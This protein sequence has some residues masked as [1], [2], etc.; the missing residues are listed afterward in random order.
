MKLL[1]ATNLKEHALS[2]SLIET[3]LVLCRVGLDDMVFLQTIPYKGW[4]GDLGSKG[5]SS[6]F[7][8]ETK[9]SLPWVLSVAKRENVSLIA[10]NLDRKARNPSRSSFIKGIT[11]RS[12]VPILITNGD[13]T[14]GKGLFEHVVFA[15]DWSPASEKALTFLLGF[16]KIIGE[17]DI[18]NVIKGKLTLKNMRELKE[19]LAHIRKRCL[20][21]KIDAETHIYAG[22]T[23]EEIITASRDYKATLIVMGTLSKKPGYK[24][25]LGGSLSYGIAGKAAVPVLIV[26]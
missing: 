8:V 12:P 19:R 1:Y 13:A 18:V 23:S 20:D 4:L 5:I 6:R 7:L 24:E 10:V 2:Y 3:M 26:P 22:K 25:I 17:M 16:K 21:E 11:K 15:T 14:A 9:L